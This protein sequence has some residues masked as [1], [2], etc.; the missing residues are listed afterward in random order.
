MEDGN[1]LVVGSSNDANAALVDSL[2]DSVLDEP[3]ARVPQVQSPRA[4][5][6]L[7]HHLPPAQPTL[8]HELP[9]Q[10]SPEGAGVQVHFGA[11]QETVILR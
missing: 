8:P 9:R 7:E 3:P 5:D 10:G 11:L 6:R 2:L 4:I 1:K